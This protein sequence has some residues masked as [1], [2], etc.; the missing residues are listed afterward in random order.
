MSPNASKASPPGRNL[1]INKLVTSIIAPI[2]QDIIPSL[3]FHLVC[4]KPVYSYIKHAITTLS[5]H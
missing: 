5:F 3:N 2:R 1:P 4:I